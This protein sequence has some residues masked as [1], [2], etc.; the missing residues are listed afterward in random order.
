MMS[1]TLYVLWRAVPLNMWFGRVNIQRL[2][3][4]RG[5]FSVTLAFLSSQP[6]GRGAIT[7]E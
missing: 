6:G 3:A 1:Q 5:N 4:Q 2:C 7:R